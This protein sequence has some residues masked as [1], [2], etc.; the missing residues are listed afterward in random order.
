VIIVGIVLAGLVILPLVRMILSSFQENPPLST[1][2]TLRHYH[3]A[4]TASETYTSLK[5][6]AIFAFG[7][8]TLA[9]VL[10]FSLAWFSVRTNMP[11][12]KLVLPIT[13]IPLILPGVLGSIAWGFL[14]SPRTGLINKVL[15][16]VFGLSSAPFNLYSMP[17][18]IW[19]QGIADTPLAF[20]LLSAAFKLTDPTLEESATM[21]GSTRAQTMRRVTIPLLRP[22]ILSAYLLVFV[23]SMEAFDVPGVIGLQARVYVYTSE[24][25]FAFNDLPS[26]YGRGTALAAGLLIISLIGVVLYM[27]AVRQS[28]RFATVSGKGFRP[29]RTDIGRLRWFGTAF[30]SLYMLVAVLLPLFVIVWNSFMPYVQVPTSKAFHLASLHNYRL[31]FANDQF[32]TALKDSLILAV[33]TATIV[34]LVTSVI[35]WIAYKSK[36][37]GRGVLDSLSMGPVAIPGV[38]LGVALIVLYI[39]SPVPIYGTIWILLIAFVTKNLPYGMRATSSSMLQ[40]KDE[41]QEAAAMSGATWLQTFRRV[42]L[43]LIMPGFIA[44]W[45]YVA[46]MSIREFGTAV[47]VTSSQNPVLSVLAFQLNDGGLLPEAAALGTVMVGGLLVIVGVAS[48]FTR[49][50]GMRLEG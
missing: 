44:G 4:Y 45:V 24:I 23:L 2:S 7:A 17:G 12:A 25:Y 38:V 28:E 39:R 15:M 31:L 50:N 16:N 36:V 14:L 27:R 13:I 49:H 48:R 47:I 21:S 42:T 22:A 10:G 30:V 18:M 29:T 40:V 33:L 6:T 8:A 3:D 5:N 19:V 9:M 1:S 32:H 46:I 20:L 41:L 34:M 26:D 43:P 35:S 37:K 11:L